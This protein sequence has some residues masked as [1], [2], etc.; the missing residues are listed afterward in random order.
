MNYY[1]EN[2]PNCERLVILRLVGMGMVD[3]ERVSYLVW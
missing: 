2:N 3:V 1:L